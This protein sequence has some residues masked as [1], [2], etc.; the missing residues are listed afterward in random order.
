[1]Q[2]PS[3]GRTWENEDLTMNN[4]T[5]QQKGTTTGVNEDSQ[6]KEEYQHVAKKRRISQKSLKKMESI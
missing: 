3:K 4:S 5:I 1:M 2:P 6:S